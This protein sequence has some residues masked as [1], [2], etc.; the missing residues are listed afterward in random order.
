MIKVKLYT[1]KSTHDDSPLCACE[2]CRNKKGREIT[3]DVKREKIPWAKNEPEFCKVDYKLMKYPEGWAYV[4]K[5]ILK[6][7][8]EWT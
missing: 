7:M 1:D 3:I 2:E 4:D 8:E 6:M 5:N